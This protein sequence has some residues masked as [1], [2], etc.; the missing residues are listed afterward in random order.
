MAI[1]I[2]RDKESS[3]IISYHTPYSSTS[4]QRLHSRVALAG[5]SVYWQKIFQK[6]DD[7]TL[8]LLAMFWYP[9]YAWDESLATLWEHIGRLV[10]FTLQLSSVV[11]CQSRRKSPYFQ[12]TT[13]SSPK[14][15]TKSVLT[16]S[17][18][19]AFWRISVTL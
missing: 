17:T 18:T 10:S 6:S 12:P 4:A 15:F 1:H 16:F 3:T 2:I 13:S 11:L 5:E 14:N 19:S 9:L 7:P 8:V